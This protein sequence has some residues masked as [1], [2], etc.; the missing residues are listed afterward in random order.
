MVNRSPIP[1]QDKVD[2]AAGIGPTERRE[3]IAELVLSRDVVSARDLAAQF[4]VSLM[5]V[6]RDLDELEA[7]GVLRKTRGGAT[8]QPSSLFESTVRFRLGAAR[9]EKDALAR[10]ALASIEPGQAILL[11]DATT[12]LALARLL[13]G[14][15]PLTVITNFRPTIEA[16]YGAADIRL[17]ALGGEYFPTHDSFMGVVCED[18]LA[19]IRADVFF[20]STSAVSAGIA[21]HQEQVTVSAK[22]AMLRAARR[23][24][25][26]IDHGKLGKTAL[27]QLAPLTEFDLVVVDDGVDEAGLKALREARVPFEIAPRRAAA[28]AGERP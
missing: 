1:A 21:W 11:D 6:H 7:R 26:L 22:R 14:A 25:L 18:A 9:A 20:M 4:D 24:V 13:P 17:I 19:S 15:G 2:G 5:T 28:P 8:A 23:R 10:H 27:H 12:T 3:R 16:L